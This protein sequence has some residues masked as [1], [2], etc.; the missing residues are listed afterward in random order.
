[1]RGALAFEFGDAAKKK[2]GKLVLFVEWFSPIAIFC[3][4]KT[5]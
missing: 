2:K 5:D 4:Y 3:G 1:M